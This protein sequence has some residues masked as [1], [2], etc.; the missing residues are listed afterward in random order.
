MSSTISSLLAEASGFIGDTQ[1]QLIP[2]IASEKLN[3]TES[4]IVMPLT[5]IIT[6]AGG[7]V[8]SG[9]VYVLTLQIIIS[10]GI[11]A[12]IRDGKKRQVLLNI[13][14]FICSINAMISYGVN[15][16]MYSVFINDL[17]TFV[18]F[19][20]VQYGLTIL[21]HNTFIRFAVIFG[22]KTDKRKIDSF[23][24]PFYILPLIGELFPIDLK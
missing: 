15:A 22:F 5:S 8:V 3:T 16:T 12:G 1:S 7:E 20:C 4:A 24:F 13:I 14:C 2:S 18:T 19:L 23:F 6:L 9:M 11:H 17:T 21:N 10:H